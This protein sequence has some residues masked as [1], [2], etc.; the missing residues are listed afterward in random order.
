MLAYYFSPKPL[1][2]FVL[3]FLERYFLFHVS[4]QYRYESRR[5]VRQREY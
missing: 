5:M 1:K 2:K 3:S 4:F